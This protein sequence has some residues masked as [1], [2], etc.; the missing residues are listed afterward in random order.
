MPARPWHRGSLGRRPGNGSFGTLDRNPKSQI[1]II[2]EPR[3]IGLRSK[4]TSRHPKLPAHS[5]GRPSH[6]VL[7]FASPG[8]A[9][10]GRLPTLLCVSSEQLSVGHQ[11]PDPAPSRPPV[12]L[13]V[14]FHLVFSPVPSQ[15]SSAGPPLGPLS[16]PSPEDSPRADTHCHPAAVKP[17]S[18]RP[19]SPRFNSFN[20]LFLAKPLRGFCL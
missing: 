6:P 9:L 8:W 2:G 13:L 19:C 18:Q 7:T 3:Q 4:R 11:P 14:A 5:A 20:M 12:P 15:K 10:W 1:V 16:A 17:I